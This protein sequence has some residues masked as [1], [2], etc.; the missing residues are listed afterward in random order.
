MA[1][2]AIVIDQNQFVSP[3]AEQDLL[4]EQPE[5]SSEDL[6]EQLAEQTTQDD[7]QTES[8]TQTDIQPEISSENPSVIQP[9][10]QEEVQNPDQLRILNRNS[11]RLFLWKI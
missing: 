11:N 5:K 2:E 3:P 10:S 8:D 4:Q 7:A 6:P 9:E 1:D